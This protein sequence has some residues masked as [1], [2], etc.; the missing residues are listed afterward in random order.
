MNVKRK[1]QARIKSLH[2]FITILKLLTNTHL[3]LNNIKNPINKWLF[4]E[5]K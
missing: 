1:T 2:Q 4:A 3:N 5:E